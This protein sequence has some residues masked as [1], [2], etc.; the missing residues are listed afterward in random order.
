MRVDMTP[1]PTTKLAI[2]I[3]L[4]Q[5]RGLMHRFITETAAGQFDPLMTK[6]LFS[7][8]LIWFNNRRKSAMNIRAISRALELT[9]REKG[10]NYET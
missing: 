5:L 6:L 8:F 3:D 7:S 2:A 9:N 10:D 1:P 4:D